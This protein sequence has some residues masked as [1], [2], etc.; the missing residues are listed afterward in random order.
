M[1]GDKDSRWALVLRHFLDSLLV[2]CFAGLISALVLH[3]L[4]PALSTHNIGRIIAI[5]Q[6]WGIAVAAVMSVLLFMLAGS[7]APRHF[8]SA[9]SGLR[10]LRV[11]WGLVIRCWAGG[12]L[13]IAL[14]ALL[15]PAGKPSPDTHFVPLCI[16][17]YTVLLALGLTVGGIVARLLRGPVI[18]SRSASTDKAVGAPSAGSADLQAWLTEDRPIEDAAQSLLPSHTQTA[19]RILE[20]LIA[21]PGEGALAPN[22][23]IIGPYGSGKT[24]ICNQ[25]QSEYARLRPENPHWPPFLFCRFEGWQYTTA[26]AALRGLIETVT[27][28]LL[29]EADDCCLWSLGAE[30]VQAVREAGFGWARA[31]AVFLGGDRDPVI[32]LNRLGNLLVRLNRRLVLFIDDL[33]RI[34]AASVGQQQAIIQALNQFQTV[35]NLQYVIAVGPAHWSS[36]STAERRPLLDLLKLTQFQELV[37]LLDPEDVLAR[38]RKLRDRAREA[39]SIYLPWAEIPSDRDPLE[40]HPWYRWFGNRSSHL[41]LILAELLQTPRELKTALRETHTLWQTG[42]KGEINWYDLLLANALKVSEPGVFEWILRDKDNFIIQEMHFGPS[43]TKEREEQAKRLNDRLTDILHGDRDTR[44]E[45]VVGALRWLFP[46]FAGKIDALPSKPDEPQVW[47]Q[48]LAATPVNGNPYLYRFS[49]GRVPAGE[50]PDR[51]ALEYIKKIRDEGFDPAAFEEAYLQSF[52][53]LTGPLNKVIQFARFLGKDNA[54]PICDS[55]LDWMTRPKSIQ[56]WPEPARFFSSSAGDIYHILWQ[57][58]VGGL[59]EWL[60][61]RV[62]EI[63]RRSPLLAETL[64]DILGPRSSSSLPS[65]INPDEAKNLREE[66]AKI[67]AQEFVNGPQPL[68]PLVIQYRFELSH[69]L[70]LFMLHP[71]YEQLRTSLTSKLVQESEQDRTG[72]L[73]REI[74]L[75]LIAEAQYPVTDAPPPPEAYQITYDKALNERR[76]DMP[77]LLPVIQKWYQ[78]GVSDALAQRVIQEVATEYGFRTTTSS[79]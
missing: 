48:R 30:Y 40:L 63:G 54:I 74:L 53:K 11:H 20:R 42:L 65:L 25:V 5:D 78:A 45:T 51:P 29:Q 9:F 72:V 67:A 44:H 17:G 16:V 43:D 4:I 8:L 46:V 3:F 12:C 50:I 2:I 62:P 19:V 39:P 34:E 55:I 77:M 69:L 23:A 32:L 57:N 76:F 70:Q 27:G 28:R 49:A 73:Q 37:P 60:H 18:T 56:I 26:E 7:V 1:T 61:R 38:V 52:E 15:P 22:I 35:S 64:I 13:C 24:S 66:L 21:R 75:A 41:G 36:P 71:D 68:A 59:S 14:M 79:P 6:H 10:H 33:D 31:V 58:K 47:N